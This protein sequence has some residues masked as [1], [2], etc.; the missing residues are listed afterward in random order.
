MTCGTSRRQPLPLSTAAHRRAQARLLH[1]ALCQ[2]SDVVSQLSNQGVR[3]NPAGH[4]EAVS[5][6]PCR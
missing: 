3:L 6:D 1:A 5:C 2:L 4:S